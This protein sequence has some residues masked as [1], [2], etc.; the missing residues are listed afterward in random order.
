MQ[1]VI[2]YSGRAELAIFALVALA[3]ALLLFAGPALAGADTTFD[4]ALTKFTDFLE[5]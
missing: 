4:T 3:F 1:S 2:K 5:G